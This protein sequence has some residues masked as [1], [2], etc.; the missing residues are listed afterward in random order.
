MTNHELFA[1][2]FRSPP[3]DTTLIKIIFVVCYKICFTDSGLIIRTVRIAIRS[4]YNHTDSLQNANIHLLRRWSL[5][6]EQH[7]FF[8]NHQ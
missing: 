6:E 3:S 1:G 4:V 7:T 2:A 5:C 8:R